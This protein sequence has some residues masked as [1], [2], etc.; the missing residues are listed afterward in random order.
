MVKDGKHTSLVLY[1]E[2]P[3]STLFAKVST[4]R[5]LI[6][7]VRIGTYDALRTHGLWRE[8]RDGSEIWYLKEWWR[9]A[10]KYLGEALIEIAIPH[11][12]Q[13]VFAAPE[14]SFIERYL[15]EFVVDTK[16]HRYYSQPTLPLPS[17][18]PVFSDISTDFLRHH[19]QITGHLSVLMAMIA[20]F[21]IRRV[22]FLKNPHGVQAEAVSSTEDYVKLVSGSNPPRQLASYQKLEHAVLESWKHEQDSHIATCEKQLGLYHDLTKFCSH[23]SRFKHTTER[24]D[25]FERILRENEN[26]ATWQ[27]RVSQPALKEKVDPTKM[28]IL[29]LRHIGRALASYVDSSRTRE[30]GSSNTKHH[31]NALAHQLVSNRKRQL[32]YL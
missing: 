20:L 15:E 1:S 5:T 22:L 31:E 11:D 24:L 14:Y 19:P 6:D 12:R 16:N 28:P 18:F 32:Y 8:D 29:S 10:E 13:L 30:A 23:L 7:I 2:P 17:S 3:R 26:F 4:A 9:L 27:S 21:R 25:E